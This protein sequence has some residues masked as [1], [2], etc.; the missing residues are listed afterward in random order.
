MTNQQRLYG[1]T[2]DSDRTLHQ[3]RP[4]SASIDPD[5]SI[6]RGDPID[7]SD[8]PP[9]G[10]VLLRLATDRPYYSA[11]ESES[12]DYVLRFHRTC[13]FRISG[14]LRRVSSHPVCGSDDGVID[15]LTTGALLAFLL[16]LRG[17]PVL[18]ASAVDVGD[19]AIGF[20]GASGM[21]KSTLAA[22]LCADG[23]Q[24]ITDDVLRLDLSESGPPHVHL[25]ATELRLRKGADSL[26]SRFSYG[27]P[28]LRTSADNRQV[29]RLA[30]T[31]A[32]KLP[33]AALVIPHP[34]HA[35]PTLGIARLP[36]QE[37]V[38]ALL[39]FPR[40]LG[41]Q[42]QD[43]VSSH[44]AH[45]IRI[46]ETVPVFVAQIPWGPPFGAGLGAELRSKVLAENTSIT[47]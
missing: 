39:N 17:H 43:I 15:V 2:V 41:W 29:L 45:I 11:V 14:D 23:G 25:G 42:D 32:D 21:G 36:R 34:R 26:A 46:V 3:N 28:E 22:L 6:R 16:Y 27:G 31:A 18:H 10:R 9:P 37:A 4:V 38:F 20:V 19:S 1:L 24:L 5:V 13:D 33:L 35:D 30:N 8:S 47:T 7:T 44:L 40:L 12:G